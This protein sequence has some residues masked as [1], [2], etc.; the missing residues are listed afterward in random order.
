MTS[1]PMTSRHWPAPAKLNLILHITGQRQDGYHLLQTVF[2]FI[3]FSDLL[4]F[5][6]RDDAVI[7]RKSD[8]QGVAEA[9]DLIIRAAKALQQA[10]A[11]GLGADIILQ[12]RLPVGGGLG[13]GSSDAATTLVALNHLWG[14][15]LSVDQLAEIG[16]QLGADVPVFVRGKAAWA[17]GVGEQL[18][19]IEPEEYWYLVLRPD[20]SVS[21]EEVFNSSDL[22]RNTPAIRI[23]DFP[24]DGG[25]NDCESVVRNLYSQVAEALDWLGQFAVARMTGTGSCIFAGFDKQQQAES[26]YEKLPQGWEGFVVKGLNNSPLQ[27]RLQQ[28]NL[29]QEK[30]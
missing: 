23:R 9:D 14:L 2:Q 8:W 12:K 21:T 24:E 18:T 13:G 20:C 27:I 7:T 6:L 28:E 19:A 17:E 10:S 4:D 29:A 16:L 3:D 1:R 15:E 26:V 25:H 11:C 30:H 22:T 5:N